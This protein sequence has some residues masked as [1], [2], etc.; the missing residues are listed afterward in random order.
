MVDGASVKLAFVNHMLACDAAY[1]CRL[2][3]L[4]EPC[5][6]SSALSLFSRY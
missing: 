5:G 2:S 1:I 3:F 6:S 4:G